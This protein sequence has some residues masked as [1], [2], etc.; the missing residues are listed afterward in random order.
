M[1]NMEPKIARRALNV[2]FGRPTD[3]VG[4]PARDFATRCTNS[5]HKETSK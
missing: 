4:Q 1:T 5:V 3:E 2:C